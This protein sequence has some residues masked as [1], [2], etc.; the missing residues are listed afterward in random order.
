MAKRINMG[1]TLIELIVSVSIAAIL[2]SVGIPSFA[3]MIKNSRQSATYN[4]F[5]ADLSY[6]RSEAV[7]RS[8][9]VTVCA[10]DS[11]TA[12]K[13]SA[14]WDDG[15]LVFADTSGDGSL[16]AGETIIKTSGALEDSQT[17]RPNGFT[18]AGFLQYRGRGNTDSTGIFVI[19]D[20]RGADE[21]KAINIVLTGAIRKAVDTDGNEIVEDMAGQDISCP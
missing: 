2:I 12:C 13:N 6:A 10:R 18:N 16:D 7:K 1:F 3:S 19:C 14:S 20:D 4:A 21:A 8:D 11:D 17:L 15:W 9:I 5:V